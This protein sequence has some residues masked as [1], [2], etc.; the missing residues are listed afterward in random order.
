MSE[1]RVGH[2]IQAHEWAVLKKGNAS[3]HREWM[4]GLGGGA[5]GF[6]QNV[7]RVGAWFFTK[8]TSVKTLTG[9]IAV[10]P[11]LAPI[12]VVGAFIFFAMIAAAFAIFLIC[13]KIQSDFSSAVK[14]IDGRTPK[15]FSDAS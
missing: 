15:P 11:A 1:K 5:L 14:E 7:F 3:E 2:F 13:R 4:I 12:D 10:P 9:E 6:F 8:P